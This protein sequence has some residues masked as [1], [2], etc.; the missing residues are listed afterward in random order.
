MNCLTYLATRTPNGNRI[1]N[2]IEQ[3][4]PWFLA[5][6]SISFSPRLT[7]V[8]P[9]P[10]F[11]PA[12]VPPPSLPCLKILKDM[13]MGGCFRPEKGLLYIDAVIFS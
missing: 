9:V 5:D 12:S 10:S 7:E 8:E 2:P 13:T 1:R 4:R 11:S 3:S 6:V